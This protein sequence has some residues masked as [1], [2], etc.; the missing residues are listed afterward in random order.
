MATA[1]TVRKRNCFAGVLTTECER[2]LLFKPKIL[3]L[4]ILALSEEPMNFLVTW[5]SP[6]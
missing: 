1:S 3:K 4:R 5:L 2:R 6:L